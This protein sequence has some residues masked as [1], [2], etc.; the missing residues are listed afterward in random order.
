MA[1]LEY[2]TI[3]ADDRHNLPHTSE[4]LSAS[5]TGD[6]CGAAE[7][8]QRSFESCIENPALE[9]LAAFFHSSY[10]EFNIW[11]FGIRATAS[12][13][14]SLDYRLRNHVDAQE[15]IRGLL[16]DL[17]KSIMSCEQRAVCKYNLVASTY[18]ANLRRSD[19]SK[20]RQS[21]VVQNIESLNSL[22]E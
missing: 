16:L 19:E 13:K 21:R 2:A 15:E 4:G 8:C 14:S 11:C 10:G 3:N 22:D 12:G 5:I 17:A 1:D 9:N 18:D 7:V 6:I 20:R